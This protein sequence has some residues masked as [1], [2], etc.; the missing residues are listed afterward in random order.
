MLNKR[1]LCGRTVVSAICAM[2]SLAA[3]QEAPSK[4]TG[5]T[6]IDAVRSTLETQPFIRLQ[7]AQV[8]TKQGIKL[9]AGAPFD[10]LLQTSL[11]LNHANTPLDTVEATS[12]GVTGL[13]ELSNLSNYSLSITK[14]FRNGTSVASTYQANRNINNSIDPAVNTSQLN[15]TVIV[16]LG[17]GRG[18]GVVDAAEHAATAEVDASLLDLNQ[19]IA[20]LVA[21]TASSYWN[22]VAANELLTITSDAEKRGG[23]YV[24]NVQS[25][26]EADHVPRSDLNVAAANLAD[27]S[28]NRI[29]AQQ[30]VTV[31]RQQLALDMGV[32][33]SQMFRLPDP[34]DSLPGGEEQPLPAD[35]SRALQYYLEQSLLHRA[36]YLAARRRVDEAQI[37]LVGAK[38]SLLPQV[39]LTLGGGYSGLQLGKTYSQLFASGAANVN[40]PN[41]NLGI[42]YSFPIANSSA[43]GQMMQAVASKHQNELQEVQ[44]ERN[45]STAVITATEALRNAIVRLKEAGESVKFFQLALDGERERYRVG[46]SSFVDVLTVEDRLTNALT[47]RVQAQLSYA[48]ALVQFRFATGTI[49]APDRPVQDIAPQTLVTFPFDPNAGASP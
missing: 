5:L 29:A 12:L 48:L 24:D 13:V 42:S 14:L 8:T 21:N 25:L 33:A 15:F 43:R 36:D 4:L 37:L 18:R 40:G 6:L 1:P 26:I 22:L 41:A 27:R 2:L 30:Q 20:Q 9:Q 16:P 39:N 34:I 44:V 11:T 23:V 38:N 32:S 3:A 28:A 17:R 49:V 7:Q 35:S 10:T 45:I 31:A 47:N 19:L 46:I